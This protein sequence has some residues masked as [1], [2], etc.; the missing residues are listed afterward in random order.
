MNKK[1]II[2]IVA[3]LLISVVGVVGA[4]VVLG[5]DKEKPVVYFEYILDE[6][7]SN[8]SDTEKPK[9]VKYKV[10]IEYTDEELLPILDK[11]KTQIRNNI[12]EIMRSTASEDLNKPNGKQRLREKI[13]TMVIEI[14]ESNEE[15]ITNIYIQ[16]FVI[17]G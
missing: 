15:V 13:Q 16:P 5:G 11:N 17:Q 6:E 12:D 4:I 9:I 3:V 8:L 7:Y 14:L 10:T 2:I 1:I